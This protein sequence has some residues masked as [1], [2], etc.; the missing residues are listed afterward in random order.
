MDTGAI[1]RVVIM[2]ISSAVTLGYFIRSFIV[3]RKER[4]KG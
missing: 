1:T 4:I 2:M 3:V